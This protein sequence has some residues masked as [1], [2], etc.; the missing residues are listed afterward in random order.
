MILGLLAQAVPQNP[1]GVIQGVV[2]RDGTN[3]PLS[4]VHIVVGLG[5]V[6]PV[7]NSPFQFAS[8]VPVASS[9]LNTVTDEAGRFSVGNLAPG[10]YTVRADHDGFWGLVDNAVA[11]LSASKEVPLDAQNPKAQVALTL[12]PGGLVTG[13]VELPN[14]QP[15]QNV[16]VN[17]YTVSYQNGR[18]MLVAAFTQQTNERGEYR[19]FSLS[20]SEYY[21]GAA[22]SSRSI[23]APPATMATTYF[24]KATDAR[25]AQVVNVLP[26]AEIG[27]INISVQNLPSVT[28]SG[29]LT[30]PDSTSVNGGFTFVLI[31]RD[32]SAFVDNLDPVFRNSAANTSNGEF[33]LHG[34]E[35]GAY[36]MYVRWI[37]TT[38]G[39][40]SEIDVP[41]R[42]LRD[43]EV[44]IR[45]GV[46]VRGRLVLNDAAISPASPP[47]VSTTV[48]GAVVTLPAPAP[49][50]SLRAID[51]TTIAR[52]YSADIDPTGAFVFSG[53][54]PGVYRINGP[55]GASFVP[56]F[57][58]I[59]PTN[60][61]VADI[62]E[63]ASVFDTG[64]RIDGRT[65]DAIQIIVRTDG[66]TV[67]GSVVDAKNKPIER[68]SIVLVPD[69]PN[70]ENDLLYSIGTTDANGHFSIA[71]V[72]PGQYKAFASM[73]GI[74][75]YGE[76][77]SSAY[78]QKVED[79]G[80]S[81]SVGPAETKTI[82]LKL[83]SQ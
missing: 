17:A 3:E 77:R 39:G 26:G 61:Y 19:L 67:E 10:T 13:R 55:Q 83:I 70:R 40:F 62:R 30:R 79:R 74:I 78:V 44:T 41:E 58:R 72:H 71:S 69:S 2:T 4:G 53:V 48:A 64:I 80:V 81:F 38:L 34:V 57:P 46:D 5:Y 66:A 16:T 47:P 59:L 7:S 52:S 29:R 25:R 18:R 12:I 32:E 56:G 42:G 54:A 63:Q 8:R 24:P 35:P 76:F 68:A 43:V 28:V 20:P 65:P 37:G 31:P 14:G 21:I 49:R 60:G 73:E 11:I 1:Q 27:G 9:I 50:I 6:P 75:A 36:R 51:S 15:A 45:E 23:Q 33:E 82:P 22:P